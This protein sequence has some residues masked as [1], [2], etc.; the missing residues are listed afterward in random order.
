MSVKLFS[1]EEEKE[2]ITAIEQAE[3][4]TSGEIRLH[5]EKHCKI[6]PIRRAQEVF[7]KL[8]MFETEQK[9]GVILYIATED[10]KVVIWG[11]EGIHTKVGQDFWDEELNKLISSFK[12]GYYAKGIIECI[13]D[14]G[15]K[16]KEFFPYQDGD[17]NELSDDIS[18]GEEDKNA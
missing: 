15:Q 12:S 14:I 13:G 16:L 2:I 9:N 11:D 3:E 5:L 1:K 18:Y 10:H 17:V 4:T 8:K 6:D 7:A